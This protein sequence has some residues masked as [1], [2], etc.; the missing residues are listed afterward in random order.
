MTYEDEN[1]SDPHALINNSRKAKVAVPAHVL[2]G[3]KTILRRRANVRSYDLHAMAEAARSE[4]L[5]DV[6]AWLTK[7]SAAYGMGLIIGFKVD[8]VDT[9]THRFPIVPPKEG[10]A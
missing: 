3:F 9:E 2:E 5:D 10:D 6:A 4:G 1:A 8:E 7:N